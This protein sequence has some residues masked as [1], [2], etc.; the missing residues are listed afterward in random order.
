M[1]RNIAQP[2]GDIDFGSMAARNGF[3]A[4]QSFSADVGNLAPREAAPDDLRAGIKVWRAG[5]T[6]IGR[7]AHGVDPTLRDEETS[8]DCE[9]VALRLYLDGKNRT[10]VGDRIVD[11]EP[12]ALHLIDP[13]EFEAMTGDVDYLYAVVPFSEIGYDPARHPCHI[14]FQTTGALGHMVAAAFLAMWESVQGS[15]AEEADTIAAGFL[16]M[17]R[18][19]LQTDTGKGEQRELFERNRETTVRRYVEAHHS[20]R[21][22]KAD[23]VCTAL[24]L[25]RSV[26]YRM[27]AKH[28]GFEHYVL[29]R[30][31]S[32]AMME[33]NRRQCGRGVVR[34]VA[35]KFGFADQAI[36]AK[37]FRKYLGMTPTEAIGHSPVA[38]CGRV[39]SDAGL[40][41]STGASVDPRVE[42]CAA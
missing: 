17:L 39:A 33:L 6:M 42:L 5:P 35:E 16:S 32:A 13:R 37:Q 18:T 11:M 28:G 20:E 23:A 10:I 25:S 8:P 7:H 40:A 2:H 24:G 15:T 9:V 21:R 34:S 38:K 4:W 1:T 26:L 31:L 36:F 14:A 3:D 19:V 30:R 41:P 12:G 29:S 22:I 27:Y